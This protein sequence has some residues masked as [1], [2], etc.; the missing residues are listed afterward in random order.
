MAENEMISSTHVK[1]IILKCFSAHEMEILEN[2]TNM[3]VGTTDTILKLKTLFHI[4]LTL[5]RTLKICLEEDLK[6]Y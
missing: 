5:K 4:E 3:N 1:N 6:E 2:F